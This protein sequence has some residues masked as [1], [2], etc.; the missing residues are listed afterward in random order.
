MLYFGLPAPKLSKGNDHALYITTRSSPGL[1]KVFERF[2]HLLSLRLGKCIGK[3]LPL[4][5]NGTFASDRIRQF[6]AAG[7]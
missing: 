5:M 2:E 7:V 6:G 1:N 3:E 4:N